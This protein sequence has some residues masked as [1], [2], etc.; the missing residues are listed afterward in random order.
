MKLRSSHPPP[1]RDALTP[2]RELPVAWFAF[3]HFSLLL[4]LVAVTLDPQG[5][6]GFFYHARLV[7]IVHLVTLG[8]ITGS[9]MGSLYIIGPM[10][11]RTPMKAGAVDWTAFAFFAIGVPGMVSHFWIEDFYGMAWSAAMVAVSLIPGP[12][13]ILAG[14]RR[15][16]IPWGV[17]MHFG[18]AFL[19]ILGAATMGVLLGFDKTMHFL[20]GF[21]LTNVF[22]HAHLAAIGWA[23]MMVM[24]A[25]YRLLPMV[26]PSAMPKG[27]HLF[28]SALCAEAGAAGLFVSFLLRSP[29]LP[30]F[31][32]CAATGF[33]AFLLEVRWM[34]R[35][36]RPAPAAL[37]RP[38]YGVL[39][40][41]SAFLCLAIAIVLGLYLSIAEPSERTLGLASAYGVLGLLGFL[42]QMVVGISSRIL[43]MFV[44]IQVIRRSSGV[45]DPGPA[46]LL[47]SRTLQGPA[48]LFWSLGI[49][50]LAFGMGTSSPGFVA[51][52]GWLCLAGAVLGTALTGAYVSR[53]F[54]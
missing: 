4:A 19:N 44:A 45:V 34:R 47:P 46:V 10:A 31:G 18:F 30:V 14:M 17:K 13:R 9:I 12:V 48:F 54:R 8:W 36:R 21:V 24:G 40:I 1:G 53:A 3:A 25:G 38:D 15:A 26:L 51:A 23:G 22:A 43:P 2:A 41:A 37:P 29:L 32:G 28:V 16:G 33:V 27:G 20:P 49:P 39:H 5:V 11:L 35:N 52:G 50:A 7:G 6:S 42:A